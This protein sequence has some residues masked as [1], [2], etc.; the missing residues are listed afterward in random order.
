MRRSLLLLVALLALVI[1]V[2]GWLDRPLVSATE[3]RKAERSAEG[4]P[5]V[6]GKFGKGELKFIN[7][8]PVLFAEG[9]PEEIGS[10]IGKL[11]TRPLGRLSGFAREFLKAMGYGDAWPDL[12]KMSKSM[13]PQ[14]PADYRRELEAV[15]RASGLDLDLAIVGNTLPDIKKIGG[16]ATLII[17]AERSSTRAPLFGRNLDY[18]TMGFLQ[19]YSLVMIYRPKGKHAF[20]SI[21]FPGLAGCVTA[22][23]DAGLAVATLEV[24]SS[25]DGALPFNSK[26]VPYTLCYR[27][28]MEECTT[29]AEAEKLLRSLKH[30]TLNNLAICDKNGGVVFEITPKSLV[31]RKAVASVCPCTNHFCSKE[32]ATA[33]RCWRL[34]ILE[35]CR[36][37]E[38]IGLADVAKKLDAVNQGRLTLQTM[39]FEPAALKLHL[40]IG[41]CPASKLPLKELELGPLL[42]PR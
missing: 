18:P 13:W 28:I 26:G 25:K 24:Y 32:L 21:G 39:I 19:D 33:S 11:T 2:G 10:Q 7:G 35:E 41:K 16:C 37:Q 22:I 12:V 31:V 42:K 20:A 4:C 40:A 29:V 15:A 6:A 3:D 30:T 8:L 5:Y 36:K 27:R 14:F 23:N 38:K 17:E 34:P 9:T 1:S